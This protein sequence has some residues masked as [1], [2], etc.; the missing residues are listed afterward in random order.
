MDLSNHHYELRDRDE[1]ERVDWRVG[2]LVAFG[3]SLA[4]WALIICGI[5]ALVR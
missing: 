3:I 2:M 4:L 5:W 1:D